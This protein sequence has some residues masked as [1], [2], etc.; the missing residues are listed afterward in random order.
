MIQWST[1]DCKYV[2][3]C[4]NQIRYADKLGEAQTMLKIME[5]G[6]KLMKLLK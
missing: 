1:F 5:F 6:E 2:V 3:V 4:G